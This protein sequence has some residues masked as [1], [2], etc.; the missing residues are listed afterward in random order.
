MGTDLRR[1]TGHGRGIQHYM[2]GHYMGTTDNR[3]AGFMLHGNVPLK[4]TFCT[5]FIVAL[6]TGELQCIIKFVWGGWVWGR[7]V[8]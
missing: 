8:R 3:E 6:V 5:T 1:G 7:G 2:T 4:C